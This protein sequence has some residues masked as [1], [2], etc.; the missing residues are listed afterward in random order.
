MTA[1][2]ES[3]YV[4]EIAFPAA[5]GH[6]EDV[7]RIPQASAGEA[8][9]SPMREQHAAACAARS[10]EFIVC[11]PRIDQ[12]T[13]ANA[14]IA[15]RYLFAQISGI[16]AQAPFV[17]APVRAKSPPARWHFERAPSAECAAVRAFRQHGAVRGAAGHSSGSAL[18]EI[19]GHNIIRIECFRSLPVPFAAVGTEWDPLFRRYSFPERA[20]QGLRRALGK[21]RP[22]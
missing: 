20:N 16:G 13:C 11:G 15:L 12:A 22:I 19:D 1:K 9:Q 4:F 10:F 5:L 17:Y 14:L 21:P 2:A 6:R 18:L 8:F 7:V 3:A